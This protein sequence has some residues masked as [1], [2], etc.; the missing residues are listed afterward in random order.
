MCRCLRV[1]R[2]GFYG[3]AKRPAS[4]RE[5]DNLRLLARIREHHE[6]SDGVMGA[7]RMHEVLT[8][9]GE[10]ASLNRIARLMANDELQGIPQRRRWRRKPSG[11]RPAYVRNHLERD[12]TATEP[13]NKW[14]TDITY[15][16][17]ARAGS[18]SA[19]W[20][21]CAEGRSSAGRC[22][23]RRTVSSS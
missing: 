3:W 8:D 12:F 14:V 6:E 19:S 7:P 23:G 20:S 10:T 21:T 5:K 4:P 15:I 2:S 11:V 22:R 13:N 9:E 1:S 18:T 16:R 17:T